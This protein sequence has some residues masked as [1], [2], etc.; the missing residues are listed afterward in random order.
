MCL[1]PPSSSRPRVLVITG[2]V[3]AGHNS[4]ARAIIEGLRRGAPWLETEYVDVLSLAPWAFRTWYAGGYAALVTKLPTFYGIGFFLS[5][6]PLGPRRGLFE[7][8][9]LWRERGA[10]GR[11][12]AML[13]AR[14]P[15]M[16]VHTHMLAPPLV[17]YLRRKG[18]LACP[19]VVAV[20]DDFVHR[21]WYAEQVDHWFVGAPCGAESLTRWGVQPKR[22]T[23][24]GIPVHPKWT[25]PVD[26]RKVLTDWRLPADKRIVLLASGTDFVCGP[27]VKIAR[28]IAEVCP[29]ACLA[30]LAG[31]SKKL[32]PAVERLG[33]PA[34]RLRAVAFTDR[35]H[36]LASVG[37]LMVTKAGGIATAECL[38]KSLPMV[39]LKPVPGHESGNARY[40]RQEGA[41]MIARGPADTVARVRALLDDPAALERMAA[42]AGRLHR[43]ATQT[44]VEAVGRMVV[45]AGQAPAGGA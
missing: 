26:R 4:A 29:D 11:L 1:P 8:N 43:P 42:N 45:P 38:A 33:F 21:Y 24:S 19:Q 10:L 34:D 15:D 6:R 5:N 2:S 31:R 13:V 23:V 40:F 16:I 35:L 39:I 17:G 27:V 9:R 44:I 37:S 12:T 32:P 14:P 28:R 18:R 41:A 22:I 36:E 25:E 30:V 20:T 7:R 3:G